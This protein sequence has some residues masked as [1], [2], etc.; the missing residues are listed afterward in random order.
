MDTF[1]TIKIKSPVKYRLDKTRK[2]T[3]ISEFI[4]LMLTYFEVTMT[5]PRDIQTYPLIEMKKDLQT[6]AKKIHGMEKGVIDA[7]IMAGIKKQEN[8]QPSIKEAPEQDMKQPEI[9]NEMII[10]VATHNERLEAQLTSEKERVVKLSNEIIQLKEELKK[11]SQC[12]RSNISQF[13]ELFKWLKSAL[14]KASF[15][16]DYVIAVG[17]YKEF[18]SRL[19]NLTSN[20]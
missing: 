5:N 8:N 4:D 15:S 12:D 10:E 18:I 7:I 20:R 17:P 3:H 6:L 1:T 14:R 2:D 13:E 16:E 9:T 11:A 19:D